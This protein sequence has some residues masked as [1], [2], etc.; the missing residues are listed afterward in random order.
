M[1]VGQGTTPP[2]WL[3][4]RV[5]PGSRRGSVATRSRKPATDLVTVFH[6]DRNHKEHLA[7]ERALREF[8][9]DYRFIPVDNRVENRGFARGCNVGAAIGDAP[10]I[11]FLNP[12]VG[13]QGPFLERVHD[14][15]GRDNVVVTGCRFGKPQTEIRSWGCRDWVCGAALFVRRS[16]WESVGGFDEQFV[17]GWEETDL[18]RRA[19]SAGLHV[20]SIELPIRHASPAHDTPEDAEYKRRHFEEGARRFRSKWG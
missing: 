3:R 2:T 19:E 7:L 6:N 1:P 17:W 8:E 13:I 20:R 4:S 5:Q 9:T 16:W 12:D 18:V 10:V 11:G 15:L 14:V